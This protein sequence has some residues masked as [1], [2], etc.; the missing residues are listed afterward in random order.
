ML[1]IGFASTLYG[2]LEILAALEIKNLPSR[3]DA[4]TKQTDAVLG[5]ELD[6][7]GS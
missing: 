3:F 1:A 5:R 4:L 7:V 6:P 2:V